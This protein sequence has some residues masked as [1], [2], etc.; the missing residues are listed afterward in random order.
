MND[1]KNPQR[2]QFFQESLK[3][4]KRGLAAHIDRSI[5]KRLEGPLRPPGA[6]DEVEF[7]A[8]CT[9]C[10]AC[11]T[12][13]PYQAIQRMPHSAGLAAQT[14]FIDPQAQPCYLCV[15]TPCISVCEPKAL[16]PTEIRQVNMGQAVVDEQL[17]MTHKDKVCTI[18][19]D[20]CPF[21]EE[22]ITIDAEFHPRV[23]DACVGCGMCQ[24]HCPTVPV[25]I[26]SLSPLKLR[27]RQLEEIF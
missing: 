3:V 18:C 22:A 17:C 10:D 11:L 20:A 12:A 26:Q 16:L 7:L 4:F 9:R 6:L 5:S 13:C 15:D 25:S 23:L 21:P 24:Y 2:K 19:Y 27:K 1:V 8:T 14:P